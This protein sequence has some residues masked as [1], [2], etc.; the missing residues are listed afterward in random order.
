M[1]EKCRIEGTILDPF[2]GSG[3]TAVA[4][5]QTGRRFIGVELEPRYFEIA[6]KRVEK[7]LADKAEHLVYAGA[8]P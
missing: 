7:A 5:I 2:M 6:V 3:T 8:T 4:C 1:I